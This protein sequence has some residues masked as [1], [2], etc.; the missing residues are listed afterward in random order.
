L[1]EKYAGDETVLDCDIVGGLGVIYERLTRDG[2]DSITPYPM[3]KL[4]L[5]RMQE[6]VAVVN[7][8]RMLTLK[9]KLH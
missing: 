4:A 7:R 1:I 9:Q 2:F 6:L 5:P 3:G 8:M